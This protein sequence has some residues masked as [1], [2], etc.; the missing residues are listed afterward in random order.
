MPIAKSPPKP[1]PVPSRAPG[2]PAGAE[3]DGLR[4]LYLQVAHDTFLARGYERA[5][6]EEI[7]RNAKAGKMT[8][9]RQFGSKD[10]LFKLVAHGAISRVRERLQGSLAA[11]GPPEQVVPDLVERLHLGLTDPDYLSVL[12]LVI[13]EAE[14]FPELG[15][16]LLSDD[17]YLLEPVIAYLGGAAE[18]GLLRIDDAHAAAMQLAALAS[19]GGRFLIK[20]PRTDAK[21]R[22]AWVA[23]VS[24]FA[25]DAWRP[26]PA[27]KR[28]AR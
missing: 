2:R 23:A 20:R 11:D 17:R 26:E 5:S 1:K 9:Y 22:A 21:S 24:R 14:R 13:A 8:L 3:L 7:A 10:A 16:A 15:E 25:L 12:K 19:G 27:A 18:Q 4:A 28:R 6:L